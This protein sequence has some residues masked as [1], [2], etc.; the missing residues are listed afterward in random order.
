MK[1]LLPPRHAWMEWLKQVASAAVVAMA[2]GAGAV[3]AASESQQPM[4]GNAI[5]VL[6]GAVGS[7]RSAVNA[8]TS[9]PREAAVQPL[10]HLD[11]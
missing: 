11:P 1:V 7:C 9:V 4:P 8:E 2:L 3:I 6:L 5:V 10:A